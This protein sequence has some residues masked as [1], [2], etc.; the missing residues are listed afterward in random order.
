MTEAKF[1]LGIVGGGIVGLATAYKFQLKNPTLKIAIFEKEKELGLH[2]TG[3]NSGVIHSG[4]Y[5]TPGSFK[6]TNCISGRKQLIDFAKQH[7]VEYDLCG[8]II[9]ATNQSEIPALN[10]IFQ[11]GLDNSIQGIEKIGPDK[12]KEIE[13]FT[14]GVEAIWVPGAGIVNYVQFVK[15]LAEQVVAI[16]PE[17]KLFLGTK[18][19]SSDDH[20]GQAGLKTNKGFYQLN[21][22][23][24]CSGLQSDRMAKKDGVHLNLQIV[25]FRGDY[26]E[27]SE[28]GKS[29]VK[30][31]IY[32]VPDP[33]FPFLGV[34]FTRMIDGSVECGPNA[35]FSFKREG[36]TRT[37]FSWKDSIQALTFKGTW[38]LFGK[39]YKQGLEE[40]K[41]AFSKKLFLKA[42]QKMIPSLEMSDIQPARSGVRAQALL[43]TGALVDDFKIE[44]SGNSIHV[45]N[46]PSPAATSCL[47]IADTIVSM[48]NSNK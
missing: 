18:V 2:Q 48:M 1:D 24:Y 31:L 20:A 17:S 13:P 23:I 29:K 3:R 8:K 36:Y 19:L 14:E 4:I 33:D 15:T 26:Y 27:L 11:R 39:H 12:I 9:L 38:K 46:A 7:N 5:Y 6:A 35:V 16:N 21:K 28:K 40:Y 47:A 41:R 25:G 34:H 43:D 37:S 30:N 42:L 45:L 44:Y 32:P 22:I 10:K